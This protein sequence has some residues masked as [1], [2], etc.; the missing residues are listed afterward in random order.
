MTFLRKTTLSAALVAAFFCVHAQTPIE[1]ANKQYELHAYRLAAKS[2]ETILQ[3]DP[4]EL[5]VAA[6]LA[7]AGVDPRRDSERQ[8]APLWF[9]DHWH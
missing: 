6:R 1:K 7:D 2:F 8:V 3:R 9:V 5:S 4:E